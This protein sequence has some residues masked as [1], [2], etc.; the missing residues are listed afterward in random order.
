MMVQYRATDI[1]LPDNNTAIAKAN[2]NGVL[3]TSSVVPT[4]ASFEE[5][6]YQTGDA[7]G[8]AVETPGPVATC[9][10]YKLYVGLPAAIV[11]G[12]FYV[13]VVDKGGAIIAGDRSIIPTPEL[14]NA[15]ELFY[16]EPPGGAK[17][18]AG[19]R[20]ALSTTPVL[21]TATAQTC[22]VSMWV[23]E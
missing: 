16:W 17:F 13:V 14:S 22:S 10:L 12:P 11:G 5:T 1:V 7:S 15:G 19:I 2:V 6:L 9:V 23:T 18:S 4:P 21:Y 8:F 20:V 3:L